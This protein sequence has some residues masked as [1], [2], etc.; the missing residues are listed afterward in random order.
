VGYCI[1]YRNKIHFFEMKIINLII[2]FYIF[3]NIPVIQQKN[4]TKCLIFRNQK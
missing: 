1:V 4:K 3:N 2:Y